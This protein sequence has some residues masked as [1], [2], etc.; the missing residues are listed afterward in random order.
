M[1]ALVLTVPENSKGYVIYSDAPKKGLECVLMQHGKVI[2]YASRKL[3]KYEKNY[4]THDLELA[5]V[6]IKNLDTLLERRQIYIDHKS[7]K[8]FFTHRELNMR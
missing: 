2:V 6:R 7:L 5:S 4:P 8:Y 3:K 1:L